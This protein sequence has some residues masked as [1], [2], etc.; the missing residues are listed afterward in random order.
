VQFIWYGKGCEDVEQTTANSVAEFIREKGMKVTTFEEGNETPEFWKILGG[1]GKY[2]NDP[3]L[4]GD[5]TEPR[6]FQCSNASG[7]F[8]ITELEYI[9]QDDLDAS[10]IFMLDCH[11][12]CYV[13]V[14][15]ESNEFERKM[16]FESAIKYVERAMVLN[17]KRPRVC[18]ILVVDAGFEPP[19]FTCWFHGWDVEI[20]RETASAEGHNPE[21]MATANERQ[22]LGVRTVF[23]ALAA[24]DKKTYPYSQL[25]RDSLQKPLPN[26]GRGIDTTKLESYLSKEEFQQLFGCTIEGFYLQP[27]WKQR[28]TKARLRLW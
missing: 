5:V 13:W 9:T 23:E 2:I 25:R 20:A 18:P 3:D 27:D 7:V 14:G 17:E 21:A 1:K 10:D 11:F 12:K 4:Q 15:P 8:E 24:Y 16:A 28:K 22:K 19:G 26:G 6:M